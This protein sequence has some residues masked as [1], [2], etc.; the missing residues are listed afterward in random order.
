MLGYPKSGNH[1]KKYT[2]SVVVIKNL[3]LSTKYSYWQSQ[4]WDVLGT[5]LVPE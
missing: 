5:Q 4:L 2:F 3:N 1:P